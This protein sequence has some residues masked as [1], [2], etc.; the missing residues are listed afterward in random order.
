MEELGKEVLNMFKKLSLIAVLSMVMSPAL[1]DVFMDAAWA[2]KACN[3]WNQSAILTKQLAG[4]SDDDDEDS[5]AYNWVKNDADRGYKLVQ[6]YRTSCGVNSKVQLTIQEK[7]GKA[8]CVQAGKPDGKTMN[9][10]YDY[11]MHATNA[12]WACMGRGSFGC[13]AMGAMGTGKL[14][15]TGPKGEAMRVMGPFGSFLKIAG[16][17]PGTTD[18]CPA[19]N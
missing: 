11:L 6:M 8:M 17:V 12:N 15:F 19:E 10:K 13:G 18:S 5:D 4:V 2:Q 3:A 7:D 1:A 16:A 14:K 9:F